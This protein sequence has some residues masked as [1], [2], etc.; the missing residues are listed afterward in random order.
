VCVIEFSDDINADFFKGSAYIIDTNTVGTSKRG[1][2]LLVAG[3]LKD[4]SQI[5]PPDIDV[6]YCILDFGD[7]GASTTDP[8]L[9]HAT[10]EFSNP[11]FD[12]ITGISGSPVYDETANVLCGMV[13]RGGMVQNICNIYYIDIYDIVKFLTGV[14]NREGDVWYTKNVLLSVTT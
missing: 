5:I 9:R 14:S 8:I 4:K 3:V 12:N 7:M 2:R 10:A 6:G 13:V 11:Q 1:H